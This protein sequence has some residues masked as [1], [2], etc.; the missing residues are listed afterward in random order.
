MAENMTSHRSHESVTSSSFF[1]IIIL[2]F[3]GSSLI[4]PRRENPGNEINDGAVNTQLTKVGKHGRKD[5]KNRKKSI[6]YFLN[7]LKNVFMI[8]SGGTVT[9]VRYWW[10][11]RE[12][13]KS[14]C[15][16]VFSLSTLDV[17][18]WLRFLA[19]KGPNWN[20]IVLLRSICC[21]LYDWSSYY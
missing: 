19:R 13:R 12:E 8:P 6:S 16:H 3:P 1:K 11:E 17:I 14:C 18:I 5:Y 21:R 9:P 7:Y 2:S 10:W 15:V 20:I 4:L